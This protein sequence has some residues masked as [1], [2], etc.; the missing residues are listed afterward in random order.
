LTKRLLKNQKAKKKC[1][2][3]SHFSKTYDEKTTS[4]KT[5]YCLKARYISKKEQISGIFVKTYK[6]RH[7]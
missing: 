6:D 1:Y 3:Y 4:R 7:K 2:K 5:K